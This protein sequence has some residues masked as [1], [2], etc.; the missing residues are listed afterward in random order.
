MR[1]PVFM[2][3]LASL[4]SALALSLAGTA[5]AAA[6]IWFI[7]DSSGSMAGKVNG[8]RKID[9][10]KRTLR[11][12]VARVDP[13]TRVT[14]LA[15]GHRR[16]DDCDDIGA[17]SGAMTGA[18]G[19]E[20]D[21][22]LQQLKP[23]GK[24][25]IARA[26][27]LTGTMA[28]SK[29][30]DDANAIVLISDGIETCKGDPCKVAGELANANVSVR[31]HVVGFD[32]SGDARQQ[33][34]CIARLGKGKY[35]SANSTEGFARAVKGAIRLAAATP[36]KKAP[37][38]PKW[39]E[40]FRDDFDGEELKE[41][42]TVRNPD[43]DAFVVED[44]K[45]LLL[46]SD[47]KKSVAPTSLWK[48]LPNV[49]QL[50]TPL[51]KGEWMMTM[52]ASFPAQTFGEMVALGLAN[53]KLD[54]MIAASFWFWNWDYTNTGITINADK[55]GR[56]NARFSKTIFKISENDLLK[57]ARQ[58]NDKVRGVELRLH[59]K[60]RKYTVSARFEKVN[61][62]DKTV[63]SGWITLQELTS[64]RPPGKSLVL[65]A[66]SF[67][68]YWRYDDSTTARAYNADWYVPRN[69][70]NTIRIDWV[71][72]EVPEGAE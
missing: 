72:I 44:G 3:S 18:R 58:F 48:E 29:Y 62:K 46:V 15:Y 5:H 47:P 22:A 43:P 11:E 14:L 52:K 70:E 56:R 27:L 50:T 24:T 9:I 1:R 10:A 4:A 34:E 71:K 45:L 28:S 16:K 49:L 19:K 59:R 31:T 64:L 40:V 69:A 66:G 38:P 61:P 67:P 21:A 7:I 53:E 8:E 20:V 68:Y 26:L 23:L 12:L 41:H 57:R 6:N 39:R 35:F 51:P 13:Q 2:T 54:R 30:S 25:P 55:L 60:G 36:V 17:V 33:L 65:F 32:V 37:P 42:W 63:P